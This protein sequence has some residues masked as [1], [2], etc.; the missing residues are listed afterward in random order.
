MKKEEKIAYA[1]A[2]GAYAE[3]AA[4]Q[5]FQRGV[6]TAKEDFAA[7]Y[8]SVETGGYD[9]A[10]LPIE[11]SYAGDVPQVIDLAFL[12]SL[13][14]TRVYDM[15]ISHCL[16]G[17]VGAT[18]EKVKTVVSHPQALWQ[19]A[20]YIRSRGYAVREAENTATAAAN[21][22]QSG[23]D[24]VAVIASRSAAALYGLTV[25]DENI[26]ES[27]S[28]TTRFAVFS[29]AKANEKGSS[30]IMFFTV[31]NEAGSLGR[32][33]SVIG[34]YGFNLRALKSRPTKVNN[35]EYYFYVCGDGDIYG[36]RGQSMLAKLN[37][38]CLSVK[39]AGTY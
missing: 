25:L 37:E 1:G 2:A 31:K 32:A 19:C 5:L 39:I 16:L 21:A 38:C 29:K 3:A 23:D 14:I 27:A 28:N 18:P 30:F 26:S 15:E 13:N 8:E 4:K 12:G 22:A 36:E 6:L 34:D 24:T 35:W 11:N 20:G 9:C 17:V 7:A 33:V 10:V